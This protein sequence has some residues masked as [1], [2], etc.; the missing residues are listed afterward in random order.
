[1]IELTI[2]LMDFVISHHS[3]PVQLYNEDTKICEDPRSS[4]ALNKVNNLSPNH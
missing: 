1:M 3:M 2:H 4:Y